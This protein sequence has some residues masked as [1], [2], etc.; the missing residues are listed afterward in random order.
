MAK[1]DDARPDSVGRSRTRRRGPLARCSQSQ[2]TCAHDYRTRRPRHMET[3]RVGDP[4]IENHSDQ[5]GLRDAADQTG[6]R[7]GPTSC[8]HRSAH[9]PEPCA[10]GGRG[11]LSYPG[12]RD[13]SSHRRRAEV[14]A[15]PCV[16]VAAQRNRPINP[17]RRQ[18]DSSRRRLKRG[19]LTTAVSAV[20]T[21]SYVAFALDYAVRLALAPDR[22]RWFFREPVRPRH[23]R[24]AAVATTAATAAGNSDRG[25]AKSRRQRHSG[26]HRHLHDFRGGDLDLRCVAC[27]S[28]ERTAPP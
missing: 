5:I 25:I 11:D 19:H 7:C 2:P 9:A 24:A 28:T 8:S 3:E 1:R 6:R 17:T 27:C 13:Q 4:D 21:I 15:Q 12:H 20:T 26:P 16:D 23:R 22:R 18:S 14:N 10:R